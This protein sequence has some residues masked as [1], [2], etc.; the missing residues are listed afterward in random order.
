[1]QGDSGIFLVVSLGLWITNRPHY[2]YDWGGGVVCVLAT[3]PSLG[4]TK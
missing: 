1:M 3:F 2:Y 4:R